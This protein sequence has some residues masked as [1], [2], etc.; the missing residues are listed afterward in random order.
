[1]KL[2]RF[3]ASGEEQPGLWLDDWPE[4]GAASVLDVRAMAFDIEDYNEHFFAHDGLARLAHLLQDPDRKVV[5]AGGIRLGPPIARPSKIICMGGNYAEHVRESHGKIPGTPVFFNKASTSV[6]GAFDP[7][8][9]PEG[10]RVVD[11][12]AEFAVV[13]GQRTRNVSCDRAMDAVVGYMAL[14]DV[15]DR[16]AQHSGGQWFR[17]KSADTFCPIGPYLVTRDEI[18]NPH[19]LRITQKLNGE[20][21]QDSNTSEMIFDIPFVISFLSATMTLLP[22][23]VISTGTPAGIGS[24]RQPPVLLKPGDTAEV[25][26]ERVGH[27]INRVVME[28]Q[29]GG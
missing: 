25:T 8:V 20:I 12:E 14:N 28:K 11:G 4:Q 23:D 9:L 2:V 21:L 7:I 5:P 1:M 13:I 10:S 3:G 22:G 17:G 6:T 29:A 24:V 18:S 27:Q 26:V 19:D 15:S 16:E